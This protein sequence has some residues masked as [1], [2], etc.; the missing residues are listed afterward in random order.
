MSILRTASILLAAAVV[1]LTID[2][3]ASAAG[4]AQSLGYMAAPP[5]PYGEVEAKSE[6]Y[7]L[8][9][10]EPPAR[11]YKSRSSSRNVRR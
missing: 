6:G 7:R 5:F 9:R 4:A 11:R 1:S 10:R 3:F 2:A 8:E